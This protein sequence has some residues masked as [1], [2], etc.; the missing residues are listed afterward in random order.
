MSLA[1][2]PKSYLVPQD[3]T[4]LS[5]IMSDL[6]DRARILA[7]G[8]GI[9]EIAHRGLIS[10]L[11]ALVDIGKLK[12]SYVKKANSM[13]RVGAATTMSTLFH[14]LETTSENELAGIID[15][16]RA[17]QPLQV[18][19]VATIG[20][21][22]CTALPFFDLPVA[23]FSLRASVRIEPQGESKKISD[24][25][26]GYFAIDL[27]SGEFVKEVEIPIGKKNRASAFQKFALTHDDWA[28][29]NCGV[30]VSLDRDRKI[31]EIDVV[32]GGGVGERPVK[33][34]N[35]EKSLIG[36]SVKDETKIKEIFKKHIP[37][38]LEP[39]SD[40]RSSSEYRLHLAKVIGRRT[41]LQAATRI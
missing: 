10:D 4:E 16:L 17:I 13:I 15:A 11:E 19:N 23:L 20:G 12:L 5:K 1:F 27:R 29:I 9:Y 26:K 31:Q 8:T 35:L 3:E 22:I 39:I 33:A 32:F 14:S 40:I 7:G 2:K 37:D 28:L 41:L 30:S 21:A 34:T 24:F 25:V 36:Q 18:K 6:G 38:D